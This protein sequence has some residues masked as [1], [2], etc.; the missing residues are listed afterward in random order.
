MSIK[1]IL[2]KLNNDKCLISGIALCN[3]SEFIVSKIQFPELYKGKISKEEKNSLSII[4]KEMVLYKE[5]VLKL[6][7]LVIFKISI[8]FTLIL[9]ANYKGG[10]ELFLQAYIFIFWND[11]VFHDSI[12]PVKG[13]VFWISNGFSKLDNKCKY[14]EILKNISLVALVDLI[15]VDDDLGILYLIEVKRSEVDDRCIGQVMRYYESSNEILYKLSRKYN[16]NYIRPMIVCQKVLT[17]YWKGLPSCYRDIFD[18][19]TYK[20]VDGILNNPRVTELHN[21]RKSLLS[22]WNKD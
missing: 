7:P 18:F 4:I 1:G 5:D 22:S 17:P 14:Y 8:F 20:K 21:A 16:I 12:I 11:I 2:K 10:D 6:D 13:D 9:N 15:A 3:S 19:Y